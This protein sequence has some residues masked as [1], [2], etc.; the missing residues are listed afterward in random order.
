M[1]IWQFSYMLFI[2]PLEKIDQCVEEDRH[3]AEDHNGHDHGGKLENLTGIDDQI[4]KTS[5]AADHFSDH[6]ADERE[7]DIYFHN[8]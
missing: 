8:A 7:A 3:N 6:N 4:A 5:F 2:D 1:H